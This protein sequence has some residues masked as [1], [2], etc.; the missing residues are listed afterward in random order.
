MDQLSPL[1]TALF[2]ALADP[3][4]GIDGDGRIVC[5]NAAAERTFGYT[6]AEA[7]GQPMVELIVPARLREGHLRGFS[8]VQ[9]TDGNLL[10]S[11]PIETWARRSDDR[12]FPVEIVVSRVK[13]EGR[14]CFVAQ[15]RDLSNQRR[16]EAEL[17]RMTAE[18]RK[19]LVDAEKERR[20]F[21]EIFASS[22][23][24]VLITEGNE[25]RVSY[26]TPS[27]FSVFHGSADLVGKPLAEAYPEFAKLGYVELF[28]RVYATGD[29]LTGRE[30]PLTNRGWGDSV[31]YFDYTL[32][33]LRDDDGRITGVIGHG[34]EVSDKVVARQRLEQALRARDEFVSMVSHEL[35]N[36]LNVLQL[37]IASAAARVNSGTPTVSASLMRQRLTAMDRAMALLSRDVD[38]L[39]EVSRMVSGQLK[40]TVEEFD[41]GA[42]AEEIIER[43]KEEARGCVTTLHRNGAHRVTWDRHRIDLVISNLLS[44][45]YKYGGGKSV[46]LCIQ[47][48]EKSV[49]IEVKDHGTGISA[50]DQERI[51]ERFEQAQKRPRDN[52]GGLGLGLWMCRK[53]VAA[54]GGHISVESQLDEGSRFTVE[55]PRQINV[56]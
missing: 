37:Q 43:M 47:G 13:L 31:R 52:L 46:E 18:A 39:L 8:S 10:P 40:L 56:G 16:G 28:S 17:E 23:Y 51:F 11:R 54:H 50:G 38:R 2:D 48:T 32:Q 7:V 4:I 21:H 36:P 29:V 27:A 53:I 24:L 20:R 55:L 41:L 19:T 26:S 22:P 3:L 6:S 9:A 35:R 33:P 25:H 30:L 14:A 5:W 42:L 1:K 15:V 34:I 45:A 49:R 12:E 44:N